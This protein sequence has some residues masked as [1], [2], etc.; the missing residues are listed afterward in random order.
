[1]ITLSSVKKRGICLNVLR[2]ISNAFKV[3]LTNSFPVVQGKKWQVISIITE[4]SGWTKGKM[5]QAMS[6]DWPLFQP[7]L[8]SQQNTIQKD[9]VWMLLLKDMNMYYRIILFSKSYFQQICLF[10]EIKVQKA[11]SSCTCAEHKNGSFRS[12][13]PWV[14]IGSWKN[15]VCMF[16]YRTKFKIGRGSTCNMKNVR[17]L[18]Y[19]KKCNKQSVGSIYIQW[20]EQKKYG[21]ISFWQSEKRLQLGIWVGAA[22]LP[23]GPGQCPGGGMD[24][25]A[26]IL[27]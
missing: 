5:W 22:S 26:I 24:I 17:Y 8:F 20:M 7:L 4:N 13:W 27:L 2:T 19:C 11:F 15:F 1:M 23:G 12:N 21:C 6:V 14:I 3:S 16:C 25:S 10:L 9:L 18:A